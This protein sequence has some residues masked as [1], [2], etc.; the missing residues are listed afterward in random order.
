LDSE[1]DSMRRELA[2]YLDSLRVDDNFARE[3]IV[4][5]KIFFTEMKVKRTRQSEAYSWYSFFSDLGGSLG[6]LLGA[7]ILSLIEV[8]DMCFYNCIACTLF[9]RR[10]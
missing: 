3:N 6:L 4:V 2:T 5:A 10:P 7:S 1:L 8:L 9:R